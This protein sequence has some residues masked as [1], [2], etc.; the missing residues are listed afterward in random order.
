MLKSIS[1]TNAAVAKRVNVDFENGFTVITGETGSGKSVMI[2]CLQL[3]SGSKSSRDIVRSG[4]NKAVISAIF[5]PS[6][7][8]SNEDE[9]DIAP[10]ENGELCLMRTVSDDGRNTVKANGRSITLA[11]LRTVGSKLLGINTQDEKNFL[12]DKNEYVSLIDGYADNCE[13][14]NKYFE[15]Y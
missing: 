4:E 5:E 9:G 10:D 13:L 15:S 1:I 12:T 2:D 14:Y 7:L 3:I 6:D 8:V 11:Q